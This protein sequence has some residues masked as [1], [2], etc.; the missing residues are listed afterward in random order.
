[1]ASDE[2]GNVVLVW[3]SKGTHG[4]SDD[5]DDDLFSLRSANH[6][7][8]WFPMEEMTVSDGYASTDTYPSIATDRR[9]RW[10]TLW[11]GASSESG[12]MISTD[13]G[14]TWTTRSALSS[15][16]PYYSDT[17]LVAGKNGTWLGTYV[18][19]GSPDRV[20]S[21]VSR[22][23]LNGPS[24]DSDEDGIANGVETTADSDHDGTPNYLDADSDG[25]WMSDVDEGVADGDSDGLPNYLDT[26]SDNDG[27]A[28]GIEVEMG[29]DPYDAL[30]VP[31]VP[32]SGVPV[33]LILI[34]VIGFVTVAK[35]QM[36]RA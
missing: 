27:I 33:V 18:A 3:S 32:L 28:D 20:Y 26:D 35:L 10:L 1:M 13:A 15:W 34:A 5:S 14:A 21:M 9:G 16:I 24:G 11:S 2:A 19:T 31:Q 17:Y 6:G 7:A 12:T 8:T 29:T 36:R 23:D 22:Y 4:F 30:E 25:D